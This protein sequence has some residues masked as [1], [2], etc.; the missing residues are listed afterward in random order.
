M[1]ILCWNIRGLGNPRTVRALHDLVKSKVAQIVFLTET[2]AEVSTMER[3]RQR[4]GFKYGFHVPRVGLSG[5]LSLMWV[6]EIELSIQS[7]S[8][9]H[10]DS[11]V[12][13]TYGGEKWKFT[14]FYGNPDVQERHHSW[15]LLRR[16]KPIG[17]VPWL[18]A[19]DFNE[20]LSISEKE[21][22]I[23]RAQGQIDSF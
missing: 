23:I 18:V 4:I 11:L 8:R 1:K 2:K 6:E 10:I 21:G 15:Q 3:V 9:H 19:G 22:Q 13:G 16:L 12:Q 5:G 7:Y 14:G 20:I 17:E